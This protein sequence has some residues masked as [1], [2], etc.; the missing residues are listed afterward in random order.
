MLCMATGKLEMT[1]P[2]TIPE[3]LPPSLRDFLTKYV[4][5]SRA[6]RQRK[7]LWIRIFS[8]RKELLVCILKMLF[9]Y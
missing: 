9:C 3:N 6:V 5:R 7:K 2:P 1:Y 8:L 4:C